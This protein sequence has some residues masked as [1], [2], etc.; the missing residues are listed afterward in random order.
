MPV[1]T[2]RNHEALQ[3]KK[4]KAENKISGMSQGNKEIDLCNF[5]YINLIVDI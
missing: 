2:P 1:S 5:N 4:Y 3:E